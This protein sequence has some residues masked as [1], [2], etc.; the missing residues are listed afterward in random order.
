MDFCTHFS[1]L[2]RLVCMLLVI[3]FNGF[4]LLF[5]LYTQLVAFLLAASRLFCWY[6]CYFSFYYFR[7]S[8]Y[9]LFVVRFVLLFRSFRMF[10]S[11]KNVLFGKEAGKRMGVRNIGREHCSHSFIYSLTHSLILSLT[12]R[13]CYFS[14]LRRRV[15][16]IR[17]FVR[18]FVN[19]LSCIRECVGVGV[20]CS[21]FFATAKQPQLFCNNSQP[22][23]F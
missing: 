21:V 17:S 11:Y 10:I 5:L 16:V 13:A 3:C 20:R 19:L 23:L 7:Y 2:L 8:I 14:H 15:I 4:R 9:F 22:M 12:L 6:Y 18:S 1:L